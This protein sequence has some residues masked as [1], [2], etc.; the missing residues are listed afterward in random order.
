M[1]IR[2]MYD[3]KGHE[4]S[5]ACHILEC[6]YPTVTKDNALPGLDCLIVVLRCIYSTSMFQNG[7]ACHWIGAAEKKNRILRHAWSP[8]GKE[9][10]EVREDAKDR[11][12]V[13]QSIDGRHHSFDLLCN[14]EL[15]N[16][17]FWSQNVF[18]LFE[19]LLGATDAR[20]VEGSPTQFANQCLLKLDLLTDP[21]ST[22][23]G[24]IKQSF[25]CIPFC[26]Q[27]VWSR[28]SRPWVV[29]VMYTPDVMMSRRLG[30]NDLRRLQ[31]PIWKQRE[32]AETAC[33]DEI[34]KSEYFLMAVVRLRDDRHTQDYVRTYHRHGANIIPENPSGAFV[35]NSW[36]LKDN[37]GKY[38]LFYGLDICPDRSNPTRFPEVACPIIPNRDAD[39]IEL[40]IKDSLKCKTSS[41]KPQMPRQEPS[42]HTGTEGQ[43]IRQ[44]STQPTEPSSQS[45]APTISKTA[46][47]R[48]RKRENMA[49]G[50]DSQTSMSSKTDVSERSRDCLR[51]PC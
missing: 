4:L 39:L 3:T 29:R 46:R 35:N 34:G 33:W 17:T 2:T 12:N 10:R 41:D 22:M 24:V 43:G 11:E 49:R 14:S 30:I 36:S 20:Y 18:L 42:V 13:L 23:D 8:F 50:R 7:G 5:V 44:E 28:P 16:E 31:I 6:R 32:S 47:R 19:G 51:S 9:E 25:G 1:D 48:L 15:M 45:S 37:G 26:N 40:S 38:M 27:W 21:T